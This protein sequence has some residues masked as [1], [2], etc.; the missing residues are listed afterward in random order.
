MTDK[1][2]TIE[3]FKQWGSQGGKKKGAS[4]IR[5]DSEYYSK[6]AKGKI[7][8]GAFYC[9]KHKVKNCIECFKQE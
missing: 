4:K 7:I 8:N 2:L 6:I 1:E 3:Q 9:K 5:G